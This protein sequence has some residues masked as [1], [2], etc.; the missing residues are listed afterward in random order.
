MTDSAYDSFLDDELERY[1][2]EEEDFVDDEDYDIDAYLERQA[3]IE[4]WYED[5]PEGPLYD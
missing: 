2:H 5:H 3:N 1:Y 4:D